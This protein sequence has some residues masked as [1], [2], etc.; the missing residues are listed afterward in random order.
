MDIKADGESLSTIFSGSNKV[1]V[2]DY[3]R[4]YAWQTAQ[5]DS[6]LEDLYEAVKNEDTHFFGPVV[7]L[8]PHNEPVGSLIDG[9]Q[10][11]TTAVT[12]MC[13]IRDKV[14]SYPDPT[15]LVGGVS[16]NIGSPLDNMLLMPDMVTNKFTPNYQIR[17][18]FKEYIF[19][20]LG[21]PN[22]K[23]F[24]GPTQDLSPR[25]KVA[26]S[27]LKSAYNRIKKSIDAWVALQGE[28]HEEQK[29][30]IHK[31]IQTMS[32][33]MELLSM[34]V[35][36]EDDAYILF[37]T[38]NDRG[39]RLTPSD[40]LKSYT[41][42][43]VTNLN[44]DEFEQ[45][46]HKWDQAV[47]NLQGYPF[48]KFLRH[49]LLTIQKQ[50]VQSKKIFSMFSSIIDGYGVNG[51]LINLGK[52]S[53]ASSVYAQLLNESSSSGS[54]EL[55]R[56]LKRLNLFSETH[57]VYL[58]K[59]FL[60]RHSI[61]MKIKASRAIEI[62]AFRWILT[63]GNAQEIESFYQDEAQK[64]GNTADEASLN[65]SISR[66]LAKAPGD[67]SVKSEILYNPAKK[68][69][70][71]YVF[72]KINLGIAQADFIWA[73]NQLHIE[74]LAPQKPATSDSEWYR[75]VA[76]KNP[77]TPNEESYDDFLD[78]WGN[79]SILEFEINTSIQ[80][81]EWE[82]KL[83]GLP[84][85]PGL[86]SSQVQVTEDVTLAAKWDRAEIMHRTTWVSESIA[87]LT[88]PTVIEVG[89]PHITGYIPLSSIL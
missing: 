37:E 64:L 43:G 49:Y 11:I 85:K 89:E 36:S 38:L 48:T 25:E 15:I 82:L 80:N 86:K 67:E 88:N 58:L 84:D 71:F 30:A 46:L 62:L 52:V 1:I 2:P 60:L 9:Q 74:H 63:G 31:L 24:V 19:L 13:A 68:D 6:F 44:N 8:K 66:I 35:Y 57:R 27:Q 5:V 4:N 65:A 39:L 51:G 83:D 73:Q 81:A 59:V 7:L 69:L 75:L 42:K 17:R 77:A 32:S 53:E 87:A 47:E 70:Q 78:K 45:A 41:L 23:H 28:S 33:G 21:S 61:P 56:C 34:R 72:K 79:L 76:P 12:M 50:K 20:P 10:R 18:V 14:A 40:L 54:V 55:D 29:L 22:R 26:T 3:Q 16:I